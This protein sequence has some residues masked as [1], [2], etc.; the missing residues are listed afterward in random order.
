MPPI[1]GLV[2]ANRITISGYGVIGTLRHCK[3]RMFLTNEAMVFTWTVNKFIPDTYGILTSWG[4]RYAF[5][6]VWHKNDGP[7]SPN[8]PRYVGEF[9]VVGKKGK[10]QFEET[11]NFPTVFYAPRG[12]HSAKPEQFYDLLRRVT[13]AHEIRHIRTQAH[14][15]L[16]FVGQ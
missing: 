7:Q 8:T 9:I 5:T 11:R 15:R 12:G 6:M 13:P 16:P 10:P 1:L 2:L 14:S 4:L 3:L